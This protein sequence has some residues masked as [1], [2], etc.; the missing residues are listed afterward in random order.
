MDDLTDVGNLAIA[1]ITEF[2]VGYGPK[3]IGGAVNVLDRIH[4][5]Q[6]D[7]KVCRQADRK[8]RY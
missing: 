3:I 2:A 7:C 8:F 1:K 5:H 4:D 6:P